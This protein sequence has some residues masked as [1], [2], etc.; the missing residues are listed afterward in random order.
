MIQLPT[1]TEDSKFMSLFLMIYAHV[2][3]D[4]KF[5]SMRADFCSCKFEDTVWG[6]T[7]G[8]SAFQITQFYDDETI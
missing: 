7:F 4:S 2:T 6:P 5:V 3:E 8:V 1:V